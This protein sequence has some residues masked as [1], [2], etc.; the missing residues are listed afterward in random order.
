[1]TESDRAKIERRFISD[2]R[3]LWP[4][5]TVPPRC[6]VRLISWLE[7]KGYSISINQPSVA[8]AA[9]PPEQKE[10]E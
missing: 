4:D 3:A 9:D 5:M 6:I 1:M 2:A 7:K 8:L 10:D